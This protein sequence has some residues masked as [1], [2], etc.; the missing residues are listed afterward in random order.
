MKAATKS[1]NFH[2]PLPEDVYLS[3][4]RVAEVSKTP[5][6][7]LARDAISRWL[8]EEEKNALSMQISEYAKRNAG[9][10]DD[11]DSDLEKASI[12]HLLGK[13]K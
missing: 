4:K 7:Q 8:K 10:A 13:K 2:V 9:S 6:T 1:K 12:E 5:A 11:L 3:L